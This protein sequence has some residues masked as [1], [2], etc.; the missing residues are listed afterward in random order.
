MDEKYEIIYSYITYIDMTYYHFVKIII[1]WNNGYNSHKHN[2][3][4]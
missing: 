1:D 2:R 4:Q 3:K